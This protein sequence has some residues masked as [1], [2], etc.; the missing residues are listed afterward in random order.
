MQMK[1]G[2]TFLSKFKALAD[3]N[4]NMVIMAEFVFDWIEKIVG[5]G[6]NTG[7]HHFL[8]FQ[9]CFQNPSFSGSLKLRLVWERVWFQIS[10][11]YCEKRRIYHPF[12]SFLPYSTFFFKSINSFPNKPLFLCICSTGLLKTLW[13]KE[14]LLVTSNFSFPHSIFYLF[15]E[16]SAIFIKFKIV[17]CKLFQFGRP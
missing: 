8:L 15:G 13:E 12:L 9:Q 6:V 11:K 10:W 16:L 1:I 7:Y 14:K 17:V 5:Q 3:D 4:V 2:L